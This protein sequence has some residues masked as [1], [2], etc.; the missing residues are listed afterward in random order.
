MFKLAIWNAWIL[1][2]TFCGLGAFFIG[3]KKNI[4]KRLADMDGYTTKEKF[5][6]IWI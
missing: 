6:T 2:I 5:F 4:A 1:S 3:N